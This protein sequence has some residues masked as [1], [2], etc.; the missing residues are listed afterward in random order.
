MLLFSDRIVASSLHD[1]DAGYAEYSPGLT[2]DR[3][4]SD[5]YFVVAVHVE[6]YDRVVPQEI[7]N[8]LQQCAAV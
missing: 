3:R 7:K 8:N 6:F 1:D 5:N 4:F 2:N